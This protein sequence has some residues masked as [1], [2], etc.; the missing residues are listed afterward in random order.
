M[1]NT[2][3]RDPGNHRGGPNDVHSIS[4]PNKKGSTGEGAFPSSNK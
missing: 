3:R 1:P 4:K 2:D